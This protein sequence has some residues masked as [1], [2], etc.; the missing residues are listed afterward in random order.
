YAPRAK[1]GVAQEIRAARISTAA[2]FGSVPTVSLCKQKGR[3]LR[4]LFHGAIVDQ[5]ASALRASSA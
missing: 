2:I 3:V 5:S 1:L 4:G